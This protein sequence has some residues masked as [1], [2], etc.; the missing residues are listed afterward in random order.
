E[1]PPPPTCCGGFV[2]VTVITAPVDRGFTE[3]TAATDF[4]NRS[5]AGCLASPAAVTTRGEEATLFASALVDVLM[6]VGPADEGAFRA[7]VLVKPMELITIRT[8]N[9]VASS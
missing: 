4:D 8:S 6:A 2:P 9:R 3:L 5:A 7:V 1:Q